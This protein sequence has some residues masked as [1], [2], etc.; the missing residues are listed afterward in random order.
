MRLIM[1]GGGTGGH[2]Y[3]A[4]AIAEKVKRKEPES[5]IL[6][7]GARREISS[8]IIEANGYRLEKISAS[9]FDRKRPLKNIPVLIDLVA[10]GR[11]TARILKEFRPDAV[12]GTGGYVSGPV[13]REAKHK[14]IPV[15]LHEQNV[16]PGVANKLSEKY[17]DKIFVAFPGS[18]EH[19]K[20]KE[21]I[22]VSGNPVRRVFLTSGAVDFRQ[23]FGIDPRA[24][25]VLLFG[26]SQGADKIN[27]AVTEMLMTINAPFPVTFFFLTGN[28]QYED[29]NKQLAEQN[30]AGKNIDARIISYTE[31]IHEYFFAADLVVSRSGALT[32]SEIAAVGRPSILIP[33][34]NVT[35]NH[36]YYNA[37]VLEDA[38]AAIILNEQDLSSSGL[39][40]DILRL[41]S[42]KSKLNSMAEAASLTSRP[43]AADVIYK[44]IRARIGTGE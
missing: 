26:G 38:G 12:I 32:V 16:I 31:N 14:G 21:K 42:S 22:V 5:E 2:L 10:S 15:F 9:G 41:L 1:A 20:E 3:P 4:L 7:I 44:Q 24:S 29:I 30:F 43:D 17:A 36:Q 33:S 34:P 13:I 19:F 6:F 25:V 37:K 11:Q 18:S 35:N 23:K 27:A 39:A 28:R 8:S 40:E